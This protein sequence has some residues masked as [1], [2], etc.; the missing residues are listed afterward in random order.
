MRACD[1]FLSQQNR[2]NMG[3]WPE[4]SIE[5]RCLAYSLLTFP[6]QSVIRS[7]EG[8]PQGSKSFLLQLCCML[9]NPAYTPLPI[10]GVIHSSKLGL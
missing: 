10:D 6:P 9:D 8:I 3:R 1:P 2:E 7:G 4:F 5:I